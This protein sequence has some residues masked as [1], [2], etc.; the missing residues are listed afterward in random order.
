M[1]EH[2]ADKQ[3]VFKIIDNYLIDSNSILGSGQYGNVY[4]GYEINNYGRLFAIKETLLSRKNVNLDTFT[5]KKEAAIREINSLKELNH[6]NIIRFINAKKTDK[7]LYLI[8]EYCSGG[9]LE[10]FIEENRPEERECLYLFSQIINAFKYLIKEKKRRHG[11]IKPANILLNNGQI[12]IAD[13]GFSKQ[14]VEEN[15]QFYSYTGSPLYT[16]LQILEGK[17]YTTKSEIWSLGVTLYFMLCY[18]PE[19]RE[20]SFPW[21][22]GTDVHL[23]KNIKQ[24][25]VLKF[26]QENEEKLSPQIKQLL[27]KM[28][29]VEEEKRIDWDELFSCPIFTFDYAQEIIYDEYQ[30]EDDEN[31]DQ[32]N[33]HEEL[34]E[35]LD[36]QNYAKQLFTASFIDSSQI[37]NSQKSNERD[38]NLSSSL[39]NIKQTS[40]NGSGNV[41]LTQSDEIDNQMSTLGKSKKIT[42]IDVVHQQIYRGNNC[43]NDI[44]Q[45]EKNSKFIQDLKEYIEQERQL[46]FYVYNTAKNFKDSFERLQ[47]FFS[48]QKE[49][50]LIEAKVLYILCKRANIISNE[51][52]NDIEQKR[53]AHLLKGGTGSNSNFGLIQ[54]NNQVLQ[55]SKYTM[56]N[57]LNVTNS[58]MN[59]QKQI[60]NLGKSVK[61]QNNNLIMSQIG[62]SNSVIVIS[63][64]HW[65]YF[66]KNLIMKQSYEDKL[67]QESK[68]FQEN[69]NIY[70]QKLENLLNTIENI[71]V[72]DKQIIVNS[73]DKVLNLNYESIVIGEILQILLYDLQR[74]SNKIMNQSHQNSQNVLA[75]LNEEDLKLIYLIDDLFMI[76]CFESTFRNRVMQKKDEKL[77][78]QQF[79]FLRKN[80]NPLFLIQRLTTSYKTFFFPS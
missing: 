34:K 27:H 63:R 70:K 58:N 52:L 1:N 8:M 61:N 35:W 17:P 53:S 42:S 45:G 26:S 56:T 59:N 6:P 18:N 72:E 14:F 4:K 44:Q 55:Q 39:N 28:L 11:D 76:Y 40:L 37:A 51:L 25:P 49:A 16:A 69:F 22:G 50:K 65:N 13:F 73:N 66:S 7:H 33:R 68:I 15:D 30:E 24:N 62:F 75:I 60:N 64:D 54:S 23:V 5:K 79:Y 57:N 41:H 29:Q 47:L 2:Q 43:L 74:I 48:T 19:K 31:E 32:N 71:G 20:A 67:R 3:K 12:K 46:Y 77:N 21:W 9:S 36:D 78:I 80:S 38:T 10:K